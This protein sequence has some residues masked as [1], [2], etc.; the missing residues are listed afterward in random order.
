M[1]ATLLSEPK[2]SSE[3]MTSLSN[4]WASS[5]A[6]RS[7]M[8]GNRSQDTKP[9]LALR[10]EIHRRGMR[11]RV[12]HRPIPNVRMTADLV[13]P[14]LRIAVFLDG[15]FWH[16]CPEHYIPPN[17]NSH[18]WEAKLARN[19]RRD[20]EAD[21][22]LKKSGWLALRFWEHEDTADIADRVERAVRAKQS[23]LR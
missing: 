10:S 23:S 15:C 14:R 9:E 2:P 13:F 5:K 11:Y 16:G 21:R 4:S 20:A 3:S 22:A 1:T 18:Y 19:R 8:R 17:T 7:T 12:S 6:I